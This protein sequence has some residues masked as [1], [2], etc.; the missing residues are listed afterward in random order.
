MK[1]LSIGDRV[2]IKDVDETS[3]RI[4]FDKGKIVGTGG[5]EAFLVNCDSWKNT[6]EKPGCTPGNWFLRTQLTKLKKK[7]K[8]VRITREIL[9]RAWDETVVGVQ[10]PQQALLKSSESN[11]FLFFRARLG[12]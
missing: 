6:H 12:L 1:I 3:G 7:E 2:K 4:L 9:A 10:S 8:S 5:D 11:T